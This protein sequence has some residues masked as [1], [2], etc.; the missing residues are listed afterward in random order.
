MKFRKF[1]IEDVPMQTT[2]LIDIVFLLLI[3][4]IVSSQYKNMEVE[5]EVTLPIADSASVVQTEGVDEITLNVTGKGN[6]KVG[7][8]VFSM[9]QLTKALQN[10]IDADPSRERRVIIRGDKKA[11]FGRTMRLMAACAEAGLWNVSFAVYQ[12]DPGDNQ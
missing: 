1:N 7:G 11:L 6:I 9:E 3:F 12:E 2:S 5:T 8:E 10:E 4:F